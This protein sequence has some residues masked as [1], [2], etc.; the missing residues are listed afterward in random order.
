MAPEKSTNS[1]QEIIRQTEAV[2]DQALTSELSTK[3]GFAGKIDQ[4]VNQAKQENPSLVQKIEHVRD[5][6][7]ANF[8]TLASKEFA[9]KRQVKL[10][11]KEKILRILES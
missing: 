11:T 1:Q 2:V 10:L 4:L 3:A 5:D 8:D 7:L 6:V 9:E